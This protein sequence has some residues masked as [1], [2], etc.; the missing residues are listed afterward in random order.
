MTRSL[1]RPTIATSTCRDPSTLF[2]S[3]VTIHHTILWCANIPNVVV[4]RL[5]LLL[6]IKEV[7]GSNLDLESGYHDRF[8]VVLSVL[9]GKCRDITV[10]L[11]GPRSLPSTSFSIHYLPIILIRR[12]IVWV[13]EKASLNKL[14]I[15]NPSYNLRYMCQRLFSSHSKQQRGTTI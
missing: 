12:Y 11:T 9:P 6:H 5:T 13:T 4:E 7:P 14:Q 1:L 2:N 8:F 3:S 10:K 15:N